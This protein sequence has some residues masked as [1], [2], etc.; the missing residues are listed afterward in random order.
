MNGMKKK[1]LGLA[2]ALL[3]VPSSLCFA[4]DGS[5]LSNPSEDT[6]IEK[7]V[8]TYEEMNQGIFKIATTEAADFQENA[9]STTVDSYIVEGNEQISEMKQMVSNR[10]NHSYKE[11]LDRTSSVRLYS[12]YYYTEEVIGRDTYV[13]ISRIEGGYTIRDSSVRVVG[14]MVRYG[15]SGGAVSYR[16]EEYP[17]GT[18]WNYYA[19]ASWEPV[20]V[21]STI[22]SSYGITYRV[23][24]QRYSSPWEFEF[25][26]GQG[27]YLR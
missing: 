22:G 11:A 17:T 15:Q 24:L 7:V 6:K 10:A 27:G 4:S 1:I 25:V 13:D 12:T 3:L 20:K 19:P 26:N 9:Y 23:T 18:S 21:T 2:M 16:S 5:N 14:Q 8:S